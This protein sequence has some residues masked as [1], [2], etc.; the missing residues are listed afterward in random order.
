MLLIVVLLIANLIV[1]FIHWKDKPTR[2]NRKSPKEKIIEELGFSEAQIVSYEVLIINHQEKV[3]AEELEIKRL[4]T[5]LLELLKFPSESISDSLSTEIAKHIKNIE[6]AH[7][8]HFK[9]IRDLCSP[10]QIEDFNDFV[11]EMPK[12]FTPP[13][14]P[15]RK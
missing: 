9:E 13:P 11:D 5:E 14:N 15:K 6:T 3:K 8:N 10:N 1:T 2:P 12:L 7:F 4:K